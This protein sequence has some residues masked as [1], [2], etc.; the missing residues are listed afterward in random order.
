MI[1]SRDL[2]KKYGEL[3]ALDRLTQAG[4]GR[5]VRLHRPER[6]RQDDDHAHP[7]HA[8]QPELGRGEV[9]GY[10]I[11]TGAKEIRRV[12]GYMPDFFGVYDDMK[13]IEYLEF[14]AA[15]YRIKGRPRTASHSG[16]PSSK[17]ARVRETAAAT[18]RVH[19]GVIVE[20]ARSDGDAPCA[21]S[22][23]SGI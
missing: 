3:F 11:Y 12:I 8:A 19:A 23:S 7:R 1:E 9:C 22:S 6:G 21:R 5:R 2:T 10:S 20:P 18:A 17:S 13:V 4:P 15:A 16:S 14:F